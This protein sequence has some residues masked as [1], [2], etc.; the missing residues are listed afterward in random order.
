LLSIKAGEKGIDEEPKAV[1]AKHTGFSAALKAGVIICMGG[2][3]GVFR[4]VIMQ[5]KWS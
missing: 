5:G 1:K 2:D 3:V 4:M